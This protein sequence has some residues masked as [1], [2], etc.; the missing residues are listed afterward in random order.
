MPEALRCLSYGLRPEQQAEAARALVGILG[1]EAQVLEELLDEVANVHPDY[2][3]GLRAG[4]SLLGVGLRTLA[5][6]VETKDTKD[7]EPSAS[8][9]LC[10]DCRPS[11]AVEEAWA[12]L[13]L[14]CTGFDPEWDE[15]D[16][17]NEQTIRAVNYLRNEEKAESF[18][19]A[20]RSRLARETESSSSYVALVAKVDVLQRR[21]G[22][23][24]TAPAPEDADEPARH[25]PGMLSMNTRVCCA[26]CMS[27]NEKMVRCTRCRNVAYCCFEHLSAD[28]K[29]HII[30]CFVP[31]G[32]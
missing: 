5:K 22:G 19:T 1:G 24:R 31:A 9:S 10:R 16:D 20:A 32:P 26:V 30:W 27:Q 12:D 29:R 13:L 28:A 3:G 21:L 15:T 6:G 18:L 2:G 14:A 7:A 17:W 4:C 25:T 11:A 23:E 8:S